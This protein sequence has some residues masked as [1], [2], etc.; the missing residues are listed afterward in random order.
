MK[1]SFLKV[2]LVTILIITAF[3]GCTHKDAFDLYTSSLENTKNL[4]S[5]KMT[6]IKTTSNENA[7]SITTVDV[8][9]AQRQS[10]SPEM[11]IKMTVDE[12]GILSE[13][14]AFY[15]DGYLYYDYF[16]DQKLKDKV[17][18]DE[19]NTELDIN[20]I[21]IDKEIVNASEVNKTDSGYELKFNLTPDKVK[22][23]SLN[24]FSNL[25]L[26]TG[27]NNENFKINSADFTVNI[28][29]ENNHIESYVYSMEVQFDG[30][31]GEVF[32]YEN[33]VSINDINNTSVEFP[34]DLNDYIDI[35]IFD[36]P[37]S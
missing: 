34:D 11:D 29:D 16:S 35:T 22:D 12:G 20:F 21:N 10:E 28:T 2:L 9:Q 33:N 37:E 36:N 27:L 4:N 31:S 30:E 23:N 13:S 15:K 17:T 7:K 3:S 26:D 19:L 5:F 18:L 25:G 14:Q 32:H 24:S 6:N 8:K 1:N